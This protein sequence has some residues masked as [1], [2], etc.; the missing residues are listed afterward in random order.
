MV[1]VVERILGGTMGKERV[2]DGWDE[3][4][5]AAGRAGGGRGPAR[6]RTDQREKRWA[7]IDLLRGLLYGWQAEV[8]EGQ[9]QK[10]R[11][12]AFFSFPA[13]RERED[14][15]MPPA[16]EIGQASRLVGL[17]GWI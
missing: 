4:Q 16:G 8:T 2:W 5:R 6:R 1:R 11:L 7:R 15:Q 10:P 13:A 17:A 9:D 12:S 14:M 3:M